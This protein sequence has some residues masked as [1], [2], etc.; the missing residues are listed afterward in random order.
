MNPKPLSSLNHFTVPVE[1]M[2]ELLGIVG[3]PEPE[4]V[5]A[6]RAPLARDH[7]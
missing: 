6:W 5:A 3:G 2:V 7:Y 4:R 1:R